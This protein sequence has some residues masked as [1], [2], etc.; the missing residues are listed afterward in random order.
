MLVTV[1]APLFLNSVG[2]GID[3]LHRLLIDLQVQAFTVSQ[4]LRWAFGYSATAPALLYLLHP[5]SRMP[6]ADLCLIT[7]PVTQHS[8]IGLYLVRSLWAIPSR[9]PRHL[10][11]RASLV[12]DRSLVRQI[13]PDKNINFHCT[14]ASFTV[15]VR[16]HGFVVLY[17][18][19]VSPKSAYCWCVRLDRHGWW[20]CR[21]LQGAKTCISDQSSRLSPCHSL[22][23]IV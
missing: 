9:E 11:T 3:E 15:A 7:A 10:L 13:S 20:K 16:S 23:V 5:C 14:V 22:V 18:L 1:F 19:A 21:F 17:Q 12:G 2:Y 4:P 6:S 8:A